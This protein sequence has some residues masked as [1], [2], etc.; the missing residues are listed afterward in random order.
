[1]LHSLKTVI[2]VST[3][4]KTK[5]KLK[6]K[7]LGMSERRVEIMIQKKFFKKILE[8]VEV[9]R[10]LGNLHGSSGSFPLLSIYLYGCVHAYKNN[11]IK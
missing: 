9:N 3:W 1:M 7:E 8:I 4:W 5:I 11:K 6:L 2:F 10:R